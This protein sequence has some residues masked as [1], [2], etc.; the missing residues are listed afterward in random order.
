MVTPRSPPRACSVKDL[1]APFF[2]ELAAV[3]LGSFLEDILLGMMSR[4]VTCWET[5]TEGVNGSSA[6]STAKF[7]ER[8]DVVFGNV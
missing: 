4:F 7:S 1:T 6:P 2:R 3:E 5:G 8:G